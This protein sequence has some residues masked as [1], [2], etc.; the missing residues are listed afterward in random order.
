M[1]GTIILISVILFL[2]IALP[3]VAM[4]LINRK[5]KLR[6]WINVTV[7]IGFVLVAS[8][9]AALIYLSI[10]YHATKEADAALESD[11]TVK[12]YENDKY[13]FF[14]NVSNQDKAIAFYGG[15]KVEEKSYAPLLRSI[16]D[17]GVD[18]FLIKAPFHTA[19]FA[20]SA[21]DSIFGSEQGYNHIYLMGHSLGG[22]CASI[23]L[24]N[25]SLSYDG[26]IFLAAYPDRPLR[27]SY[28][29]LS[30]YG[31]DDLV[32]NKG[33]YQSHLSNFPA[34]FE[35]KIIEGG[36]HA[37]FAYYGEQSGDGKGTLAR[38]EQIALTASFVTSFINV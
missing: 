6:P 13:Y 24:A 36:N 20:I 22:T 34:N 27:D 14:D 3:I 37:N 38:E 35:T 9:S 18:V 32:L 33:S 23:C 7:P 10:Y 5:H 21:A 31:S 1:V 25:T 19:L 4:V 8:V 17:E 28:R 11:A 29:A 26:I 2:I 16:A 12:V 30:I 15:A